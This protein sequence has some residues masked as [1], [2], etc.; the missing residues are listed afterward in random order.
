MKEPA[1]PPIKNGEVWKHKLLG[2]FATVENNKQTPPG[3][4]RL[5]WKTARGTITCDALTITEAV[6]KKTRERVE[7]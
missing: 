4:V 2:T 5:V 6:L 3:C 7:T 1:E